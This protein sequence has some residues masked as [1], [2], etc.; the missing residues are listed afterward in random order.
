MAFAHRPRGE[1]PPHR[2]R[3]DATRADTAPTPRAAAAVMDVDWNV[4]R[5]PRDCMTDRRASNTTIS[6]GGAGTTASLVV[7]TISFALCFAAWG[8]VGGLA[9]VFASL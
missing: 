6:G 7:A 9:P 2:P 1:R 8:L 4:R 3:A 5:I